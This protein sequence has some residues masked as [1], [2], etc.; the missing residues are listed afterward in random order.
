MVLAM[1]WHALSGSLLK[2][3]KDSVV[4]GIGEYVA[5]VEVSGLDE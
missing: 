3:L 2:H 1:C 4:A 5:P